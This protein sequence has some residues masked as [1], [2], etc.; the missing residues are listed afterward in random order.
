VT[1]FDDPVEDDSLASAVYPDTS[2]LAGA[3]FP[4]SL[5]HRSATVYCD[6]V[7][8]SD[9]PV[10][11]S[12]ITRVEYLQALVAIAND[13]G[14]L[15]GRVRR[16]YRLQHWSNDQVV[17]QRWLSHG[18]AEFDTFLH[19]FA[20]VHFTHV[21]RI[22]VA[23]AAG[24]MARFQIKSNDAIHV[25]TAFQAGARTLATLDADFLRVTDPSILTID[26]I[27]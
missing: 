25:A 22:I 24:F 2:I 5:Y 11:L 23:D 12:S 8:D 17:R 4:G 3:I 7:I 14:Q 6:E 19:R 18:L 21:S 16:G 27:R 15:L 13:L 20:R 10:V 26:L 9:R 1:A